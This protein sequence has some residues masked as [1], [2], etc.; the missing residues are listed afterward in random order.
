MPASMAEGEAGARL[1]LLRVPADLDPPEHE[2]GVVT[3]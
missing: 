3:E 2:Y 1:L